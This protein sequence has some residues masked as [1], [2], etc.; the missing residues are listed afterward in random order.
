LSGSSLFLLN[1][2]NEV[3]NA[4]G[5]QGDNKGSLQ[6]DSSSMEYYKEL[7]N[8]AGKLQLAILLVLMHFHPG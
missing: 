7:L 4:A 6:K 2:D 3:S 1:T 8:V 5:Q